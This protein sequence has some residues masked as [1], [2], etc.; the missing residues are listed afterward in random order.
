M[1]M[2]PHGL[3]SSVILF[4]A[5]VWLVCLAGSAAADRPSLIDMQATVDQVVTGLCEGDAATCGTSPPAPAVG[6]IVLDPNKPV[7]LELVE[8]SL[9]VSRPFNCN[10]V[11]APGGSTSF[12]GVSA[13]VLQGKSAGLL[14]LYVLNGN[15]TGQVEVALPGEGRVLT[16]HD[17]IIESISQAD[18]HG[19]VDIQFQFSYIRVEWQGKEALW[20][21]TTQNGYGCH[22]DHVYTHVDL[23]GNSPANLLQ[24]EYEA[25]YTMAVQPFNATF[26]RRVSLTRSPPDPC[27]LTRITGMGSGLSF[28]VSFE[29]LWESN[30]EF[31][32]AR[33]AIDSIILTDAF[34]E[35]WQLII[36]SGEVTE[37]V[38]LI[39]QT[40]SATFREFDPAT[41]AET[42]TYTVNF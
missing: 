25:A 29:R 2:K 7:P 1:Y 8:L 36:R 16:F 32:I 13:T 26:V 30:D 28:E 42:E 5:S 11:C 23:A 15:S 37:H 18:E 38:G 17:V 19:R 14:T 6:T 31:P 27:Y 35:T 39:I 9:S 40:G 33:Q 12:L 34:I 3:R 22:V 24:Q 21:L 10:P 41:G 20:N 4:A